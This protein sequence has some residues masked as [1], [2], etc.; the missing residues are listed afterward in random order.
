MPAV[1]ACAT[2]ALLGAASGSKR[3]QIRRSLTRDSAREQLS[4]A[5]DRG[6]AGQVGDRSVGGGRGIDRA[7]PE[8]PGSDLAEHASWHDQPDRVRAG[9]VEAHSFHVRLIDPQLVAGGRADR[10]SAEDGVL[11][12][13]HSEADP[14]V[15]AQLDPLAHREPAGAGHEADAPD[16]VE[17]RG[18]ICA[19]ER[20]E[21]DVPHVALAQIEVA[22]RPE[23]S[24]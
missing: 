23:S 9:V 11:D 7:V 12:I 18:G 3:P 5:Q 14:R 22:P 24:Y 16:V 10:G 8:L 6:E 2:S 15:D 19:V 13:E 4:D 20:P 17:E 1:V 21:V